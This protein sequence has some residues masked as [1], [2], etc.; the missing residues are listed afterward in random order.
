[1]SPAP[2]LFYLLLLWLGVAVYV[3]VFPQQQEIWKW[4]SGIVVVLLLADLLAAR[5]MTALHMERTVMTALAVGNWSPVR[6][7]LHNPTRMYRRIRVFDHYPQ[8]AEMQGLPQQVRLP[9]Q[10]WAEI[11]YQIRPLQRGSFVFPLV[12]VH[13]FSLLGFWKNNLQRPLQSEVHVYPNFATVMKYSLLATDQRLTQMGIRRKR[14]RGEGL[15]FHQLREYREGD[16]LRQIDWKAT[17]RMRKLISRDYQ[18]E[19]DQRVV[20]LIDCG[21]RMRAEDGRLS[22]FDHTLNAVLLL[23]HVALRQGDAVGIM[24]FSGQDRWLSP[25]KSVSSINQVLNTLYDLQPSVQAPDYSNAAT[26]LVARQPRRSLIV[27]VT[28]VRDEDTDDL[29]P[30]LGLL[31]RHHLV[32]LASMKEIA[33]D[34]ALAEPVSDFDGAIEHAATHRYLAYRKKAHEQLARGGVF[35]L[36]VRPDELPVHMVNRYLE[37]KSSGLL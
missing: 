14:R 22:H 26:R 13:M 28:N 1:M 21:R 7:R 24:T 34:D 18:E 25:R 32:L 12:Q 31:R 8:S 17:S 20:F 36:D 5:H 30:A 3:S 23:S 9:P 37:I 15:E 35:T 10:G 11:T 2:R 29:L 4:S 6:L 16:S 33:L 27:L 19:R